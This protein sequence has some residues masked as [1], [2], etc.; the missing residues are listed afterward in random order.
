MKVTNPWGGPNSKRVGSDT[1]GDTGRPTHSWY[2]WRPTGGD[3]VGPEHP[4]RYTRECS[5][6]GCDAREYAFELPDLAEIEVLV[7]FLDQC[8]VPRHLSLL[9]RIRVFL[10]RS[11]RVGEL[12]HIRDPRE[13]A[14]VAG[15]SQA[16][17][18]VVELRAP[19]ANDP[20]GRHQ[21]PIRR[22][23]FPTTN[24]VQAMHAFQQWV[25]KEDVEG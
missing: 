21:E 24:R 25:A 16:I 9:E 7:A 12:P 20:T 19:T 15:W 4:W 3:E 6:L 10:Q 23:L 18:S 22:E 11:D 14:F 2:R 1:C 8:K 17:D 13:K 5:M